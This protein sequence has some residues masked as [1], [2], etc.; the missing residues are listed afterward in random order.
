MDLLGRVELGG[1]NIVFSTPGSGFTI[2]N[3][4]IFNNPGLSIS[5]NG[6]SCGCSG[7]IA[8]ALFGE[9]GTFAGFTYYLDGPVSD[10]YFITGSAIFGQVGTELDQIDATT[11]VG[12]QA[13]PVEMPASFTRDTTSYVPAQLPDIAVSADSFGLM[14]GDFANAGMTMP[15]PVATPDWSRWTAAAA[16]A[17]PSIAIDTNSMAS[18]SRVPIGKLVGDAEALLGGMIT[19]DGPATR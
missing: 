18:G 19:F 15:S 14:P 9:G 16:Q 10:D 8:G 17:A 4:G 11:Q 12:A 6:S 13:I 5:N 7:R 2:Q 3:D 1:R